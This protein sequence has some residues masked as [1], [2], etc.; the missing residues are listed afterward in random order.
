MIVRVVSAAILAWSVCAASALASSIQDAGPSQQAATA[1]VDGEAVNTEERALADLEGSGDAFVLSTSQPAARIRFSLPPETVSSEAW[2]RLAARPASDGTDG[3]IRVTVNGGEPIIIRPQP[4]AMEARFALFSADFRP[5]NNV[6]EIAYSTESA[7]TGWIVDARRSRLR[8]TLEP[9]APLETLDALE[10]ALGADF[11]APRRIALMTDSGRERITLESLLA[12]ALALR[13]GAV[14]IFTGDAENADLVVRVAELARLDEADRAAL[15]SQD[16]QGPEIAFRRDNGQPRLIVTGRNIDEATA[17]ARLMGARSFAGY[18]ATFLAADAIS[19]DRLGRRSVDLDRTAMD[20]ADLRT[21]ASSGLPFSADQGARTAVQFSTRFDSDRHGAL[22]VLARAALIGGEAW[23]YAWYGDAG[24]TAPAN[25][26]LLVIGPNSTEFDAVD[27]NAPEELRAALR[28]AERSR[29]Q[30]GLMRL[31][32]AA[33]ADDG[34]TSTGEG[35][36]L[37]VGVASLFRDRRNAERWIGTLTAP[38]I[39]SFEN[40]GRQLARSDLWSALEGRAAVW[41][42]RGVTPL[43]FS[44]APPTLADRAQEFALDHTRDAAFLLFGAALLML[45]RGLLRRRREETA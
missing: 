4:R 12:Q 2:L 14:P 11:A 29:G 37:G 32:A 36:E 9:V 15:R 18:G 6:L 43:D 25:H 30:R 17:A 19:A 8:L 26:N 16:S 39:A 27:R 3:R 22:S 31:A 33:Y 44:V 38:D 28:A 35:A 10:R 42:A 23:L 24:E 5:G 45:L 41:S 34:T 21:F 40:A 7:S 1:S 20:R 13:A